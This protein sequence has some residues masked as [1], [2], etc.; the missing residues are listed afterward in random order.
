MA[1]LTTD[2][3]AFFTNLAAKWSDFFEAYKAAIK[4]Q[5]GGPM[6][7]FQDAS[8]ARAALSSAIPSLNDALGA[9]G[10]GYGTGLGPA[11][12]FHKPV[13]TATSDTVNEATVPV[14]TLD[15]LTP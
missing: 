12:P 9:N 11:S 14:P 13:I 7:S 6:V 5:N 8:A 4:V 1:A 15:Q 2:Q 3:Q 10:P